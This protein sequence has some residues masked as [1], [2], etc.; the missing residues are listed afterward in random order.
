MSGPKDAGCST[1]APPLPDHVACNSETPEDSSAPSGVSLGGGGVSAEAAFSDRCP[2]EVPFCIPRIRRFDCELPDGERLVISPDERFVAVLR[3]GERSEE[4]RLKQSRARRRALPP[5]SFEVHCFPLLEKRD[6][7]SKKSLSNQCG[8]FERLNGA[9]EAQADSGRNSQLG[10]SLL[11][12]G[13]CEVHWLLVPEE[14][15]DAS[16][17]GCW[18]RSPLLCCNTWRGLEL[19]FFRSLRASGLP[20]VAETP[21]V[22]AA[23]NSGHF[24]DEEGKDLA[25]TA[26]DVRGQEFL[27]TRWDGRAG[28]RLCLLEGAGEGGAELFRY[29]VSA[30]TLGVLSGLQGTARTRGFE[31]KGPDSASCEPASLLKSPFPSLALCHAA[32]DDGD[33]LTRSVH[34]LRQRLRVSGESELVL[35]LEDRVALVLRLNSLG[36]SL[37]RRF[38]LQL[39]LQT[40]CEGEPSDDAFDA[41]QENDFSAERASASVPPGS[42]CGQRLLNLPTL[43]FVDLCCCEG[44]L[45]AL[46]PPPVQ[47][48]LVWSLKGV[49]IQALE[50]PILGSRFLKPSRSAEGSSSFSKNSLLQQTREFTSDG[51][52][53]AAALSAESSAFLANMAASSDCQFLVF[54]SNDRVLWCLDVEECFAETAAARRALT[55]L[56]PLLSQ[57]QG[58]LLR[59]RILCAEATPLEDQLR[60]EAVALS[61]LPGAFGLVPLSLTLRRTGSASEEV[62]MEGMEMHGAERLLAAEVGEN[63]HSRGLSASAEGGGAVQVY[64]ELI[65]ACRRFNE[66]ASLTASFPV[67]PFG[68]YEEEVTAE[69][70]CASKF[71]RA[72]VLVARDAFAFAQRAA[73]QKLQQNSDESLKAGDDVE[74]FLKG[75]YS[76]HLRLAL[77]EPKTRVEMFRRQQKLLL[78]Y[79]DFGFLNKAPSSYPRRRLDLESFC[80][81][82]AGSFDFGA[83]IQDNNQKGPWV[84]PPYSETSADK[85]LEDL[86]RSLLN[87]PTQVLLLRCPNLQPRK[88]GADLV[89][90][91][92]R[93]RALAAAM[94]SPSTKSVRRSHALLCCAAPVRP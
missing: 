79:A 13:C 34:G 62:A 78:A 23:D 39:A 18:R 6:D 10:E 68:R 22:C 45:F 15:L 86:K 21:P 11:C 81:T 17:S 12:E 69:I 16:E 57:K 53:V 37:C 49:A 92:A 61:A 3:R 90:A 8:A 59:E 29:A 51:S 4:E 65:K 85:A 32:D 72:F 88:D 7:N 64:E 30:D 91:L 56:Q 89:E 50:V 75:D 38:S 5:P 26:S 82:S 31:N 35:I 71:Q 83:A 44:F 9:C 67:V 52:G 60:P 20:G 42:V 46:T 58:A 84:V 14:A 66:F 48:V 93:V 80:S 43:R 36:L 40:P 2:R 87:S 28:S 33:E 70:S 73:L 27:L 47:H 94:V 54:L 55:A 1:A 25:F 24:A 19:F 77:L 41:P 74:C 76:E 63:G